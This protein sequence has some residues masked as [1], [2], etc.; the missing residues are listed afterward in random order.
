MVP[1]HF[2]I[3]MHCGLEKLVAEVPLDSNPEVAAVLQEFIHSVADL[4][5]N[6]ANK[7]MTS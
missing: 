6:L 2:I 4:E 1:D 7:R 3:L 5:K